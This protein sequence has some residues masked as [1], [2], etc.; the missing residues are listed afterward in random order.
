[1]GG[2]AYTQAAAGGDH[3][4]LLRSDGTA[5]ACGLNDEGQCDLPALEEGVI[6]TQIA[7]GAFHTVLLRSDGTAVACGRNNEGQCDLPA[8]EGGVFYTQVAAGE[9]HHTVLLRSDGTAVA[10]GC[11]KCEQCDL[12]ALEGGPTYI[13]TLGRRLILQASLDGTA[14]VLSTLDGEEFCRI[15]ATANDRLS[16]VY[17]RMQL[18]HEIR[19]SFSSFDVVLPGGEVLRNV[20]AEDPSAVLGPPDET[21]ATLAAASVSNSSP[22]S[23]KDDSKILKA[24]PAEEPDAKGT[25][26]AD[27]KVGPEKDPQEEGQQQEERQKKESQPGKAEPAEEQ[28]ISQHSRLA[29]RCWLCSWFSPEYQQ[30]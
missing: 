25:K 28:V 14:M 5:V 6:Y 15:H 16:D 8:L 29:P 23:T 10:C 11:N 20:L 27:A 4:V 26:V 30:E 18:T 13:C 1:M 7:A 21:E 2:V 12:P 22:S 24:E 3:T 19:S 9:C 17:K